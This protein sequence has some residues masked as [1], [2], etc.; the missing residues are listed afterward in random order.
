MKEPHENAIYQHLIKPFSFINVINLL[1]DY[2]V[3][4]TQTIYQK[5]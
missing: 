1:S 4:S 3:P 2:S 5:G